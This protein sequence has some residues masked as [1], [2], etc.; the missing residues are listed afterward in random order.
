MKLKNLYKSIIKY[1][2]FR[3]YGRINNVLK[4]SK[5]LKITNFSIKNKSYKI[6]KIS[7]CRLFTNSIHDLA[8]IIDD[9]ILEEP[10]FQLRNLINSDIKNNIVLSNGTPRFLKKI[11]G[12]ILCLLTG[13]A[14]ND[15]YWHWMYDVLPRI[16]II[17]KEYNLNFFK[18]I[19]IPNNIYPFQKETLKLL[20]I[21]N[22]TLSSKKYKHIK[23]D[24]IISTNHPWQH[25]SSAHY[26]IGQTPKWISQWL[27][28]KFLIHKSNKK[29]Y[30][31]IYIDRSD[32]KFHILKKRLIINEK[33]IINF[34]IKRNFKIVKLSS[35]S[36]IEQISI[37]NSAKIIVG[38]HGAGFTNIIFCKR[39]TKIIEFIDKNTSSMY[40]K[41]S[42]DM[43]LNYKSL[44]G[45]RVSKDQKNQNNNLFISVKNLAKLL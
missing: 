41:I 11:K 25:S 28:K 23:T 32:S 26:D 19:L 12:P 38:N 13:G 4:S 30:E 29:F 45:K 42:N 33:E 31:K 37:F 21:E 7:N 10:S 20:N 18:K 35:F 17:E 1:F 9:K 5:Y 16:A 44:L 34:L 36:L 6:Y 15:N 43:G 2:F 3:I 22:K 27:R 24:C 40:K 8:F 39:K 14:G